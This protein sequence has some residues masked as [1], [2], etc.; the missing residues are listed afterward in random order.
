MKLL[1]ALLAASVLYD[2]DLPKIRFIKSFPGSK[3]AYIAIWIDKGG[4]GEWTDSPDGD[5]PIRVQLEPA[6]TTAI[7]SLAEKLDFFARPLEAGLKVAF[8]GEKTLGYDAGADSHEVKFN[9]TTD[10]N[11]RE[12]VDWFEK[13]SETMQL[14]DGLERAA[15]FDRLGVDREILLLQA[16]QERHRLAGAGRLLPLLDS[17]AANPA[18]INRARERAANIA[19]ALRA[20]MSK[21]D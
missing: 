20:G 5:Q 14:Y 19:Q 3:P 21:M 1:V 6:E 13:I 2:A 9:Y 7:F 4:A 8:T 18:I 12:L 17:I 11:G 15:K 10:Q 16:S